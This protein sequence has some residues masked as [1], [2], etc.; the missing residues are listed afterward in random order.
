MYSILKRIVKPCRLQF[1]NVHTFTNEADLIF[2]K[3]VL[4]NECIKLIMKEPSL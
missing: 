4:A 1:K 2:H 3:A